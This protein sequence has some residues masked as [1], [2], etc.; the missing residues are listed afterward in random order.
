MTCELEI[1]IE[2]LRA[3]LRNAVDGAERRQIR[4]ELEI[5]Q[6]ELIVVAAEL[7]G[8]AESEPPF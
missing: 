7:D 4:A 2:E 8:L 5:V 1:Q 3:E 6:A